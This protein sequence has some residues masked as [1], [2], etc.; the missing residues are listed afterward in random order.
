MRAK[1]GIH[2]SSSATVFAFVTIGL[3]SFLTYLGANLK[4]LPPF[5]V[6]GVALC[7]GGIIGAVKVRHWRIPL[8]TLAVGIGGIFGYHF[9]FFNALRHAP[10]VEA[11]LINYLW[12][13]L[14]VVLSPVF[15]PGYSLRLHHLLGGT[16][17]LTGAGLIVTEGRFGFDM[18]NLAGYL[19]A[20]GAAVTWASYS[21]VTKRLPPF[22]VGAVGA[23]CLLSGLLSLGLHFLLE[24][25]LFPT[26]KDWVFLGFLG[27]GPLGAAFFTWV[28]A[29]RKGDPR[30][31]G[32]LA[33]LTPLTSTLVLVLIGGC[34]MTWVTAIAMLLIVVGAVVGSLDV[35]F[36]RK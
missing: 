36:R 16:A 31:I 22:H 13:L 18:A 20:L 29:M 7:I 1:E 9:F 2:M 27:A 6:T 30:I 25:T 28:A 24:P 10:A 32:S 14:I 11:G 19:F 4:S 21:L 12:P 17:G 5:L 3:W 35:L 15:L 8:K 34:A 26:S 23:F 33:Y